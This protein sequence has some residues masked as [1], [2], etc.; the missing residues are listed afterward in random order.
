VVV[1]PVTP[2][3][4]WRKENHKFKVKVLL[5]YNPR[6]RSALA[7]EAISSKPPNKLTIKTPTGSS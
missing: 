1:Q 4:E 3:L 6:L 7:R 2:A 5:G